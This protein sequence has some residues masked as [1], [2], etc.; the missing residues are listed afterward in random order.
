MRDVVT[1]KDE[2]GIL[3]CIFS[4]KFDT[5]VSESIADDVFDH[6]QQAR[7]EVIFDFRNVEYVSSAFLRVAIRAA[8]AVPDMKIK[9]INALPDIKDVFK[10]SGLLK[11]FSFE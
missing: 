1:Y 6:I 7:E 8:R 9:I 3:T 5:V 11:I 10:V 2:N 4:G